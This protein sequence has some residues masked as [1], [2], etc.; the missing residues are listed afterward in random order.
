V[1]RYSLAITF[2]ALTSALSAGA[3][4]AAHGQAGRDF[5]LKV[6]P[7][8]K[9]KCFACHGDDPK[10]IKGDLNM[11]TREALLKGGENLTNVLV[12]GNAK[13][14]QLVVAMTWEN[15]DLEMPPKENDRLTRNGLWS[16]TRMA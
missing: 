12:P 4:P 2:I 16:Q 5:T 8:L 7:L 9:S 3:Q 15:P 10:K 11:L 1:N 13:A 6:L 14:S